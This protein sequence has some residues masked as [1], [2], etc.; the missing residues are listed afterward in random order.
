M[1]AKLDGRHVG[2]GR[3]PSLTHVHLVEVQCCRV[4]PGGGKVL[5]TGLVTGM[6]HQCILVAQDFVQVR[7]IGCELMWL[8]AC[9]STPCCF[10]HAID[11]PRR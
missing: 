4:R 11:V 10:V 6:L 5:V 7:L 8:G 1:M 9:G 3:V 2:V